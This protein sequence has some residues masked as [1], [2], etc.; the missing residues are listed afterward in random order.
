[1]L[2]VGTNE[3]ESKDGGQKSAVQWNSVHVGQLFTELLQWKN[4]KK[5]LW[6]QVSRLL[7]SQNLW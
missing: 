7:R 2:T 6:I 3:A 4:R 1:M 5:N